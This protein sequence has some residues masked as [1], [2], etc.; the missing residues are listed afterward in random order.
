MAVC[1]AIYM[2]RPKIPLELSLQQEQELQR[3]VRS[4]TS[5]QRMVRR[6]RI[7]LAAAAG[8]DNAEIAARLGLSRPSVGLW[9]KRFV[10]QGMAGLQEARGRGRKPSL[11]ASHLARVVAEA[12]QPPRGRAR[13]S[14]RSMARHAGVS[15]SSV[16]RVWFQNEIKP[17]VVRTFK[18][19]RDPSFERKFWDVIGVYL[20]PPAHAVVLCCDEKSQ[21]QALERT[22]PGLPLGQGHVRTRTHDYYRHGTVCLFAA[23]NYLEGKIISQIAPRHR[24]QEWLRFLRQIDREVPATMEVHLILDN[25][26]THKHEKVRAWLAGHPRFHLHYTPTSSSWMNLVE[27]F[28][29]D[30]SQDAIAAGSFGSVEELANAITL[31]LKERNL[32][33]KRYVWR[34]DGKVI[35]EKIQ[36]ARE[37]LQ[38]SVNKAN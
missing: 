35:L 31:Y 37:A 5:L 14:C 11:S 28:F 6:A 18:L 27:R 23:L 19:S 25:Y 36:R 10:R 2:A 34:A 30:I 4:P 32:E 16:Q 3:I 12:V 1:L 13:W 22:Q 20:N 8:Q 38:A 21:C 9:R 7:V 26:S 17:H 24:H 15:K 33:P 29:R